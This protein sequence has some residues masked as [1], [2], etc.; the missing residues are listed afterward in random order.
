MRVHINVEMFK[1]YEQPLWYKPVPKSVG[2]ELLHFSLSI[3]VD[4]MNSRKRERERA[5]L[6]G[7]KGCNSQEG[8]LKLNN[9]TP[10]NVHKT[11]NA[12]PEHKKS[13]RLTQA[14]KIC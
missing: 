13:K 11:D 7:V 9:V 12:V 1:A 2:A 10:I 3:N 14:G 8:Q 5:P 6:A 4:Y